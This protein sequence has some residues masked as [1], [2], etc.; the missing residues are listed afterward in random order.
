MNIPEFS[1]KRKVSVSMI[2]MI[3]VIFGL[4]SITRLGLD[5]LPDLEFPTVSVI[6][7]YKGASSEDIE[8]TITENI[9][10]LVSSVKDVKKITSTSS[11]GVSAVRVEF[12]WGTNIDFA[13]QDIRDQLGLYQQ[14]MPENADNPLVVKFDVSQLPIM[15]YGV[16]AN[17]TMSAFR[18]KKLI[19]DEV[20]PRLERIEG[21]A[22]ALVYSSDERE[23][24]VEVDKDALIARNLSLNQVMMALVSENVNTPGGDVTEG[25]E[26]LT[27]RAVGEFKGLDDIN[28][29]IVGLSQR[30]EPIYIKD[31]AE[32]KDTF[33]ETH[34]VGRIQGEK[35]VFLLINK[36]SGANVA[37]VGRAVKQEVE[38]L[39]GTLPQGI[40]FTS[41]MDQEDMVSRVTS[42]TANTAWQGGL[43]AVFMIFLF[44]RNWRPTLIIS[45]SLPLSIIATF[46]GMYFAGYTFNIMTLA[47]LALGVGML[48]DN[49][50]VVI[51]NTFRHIEQ[52]EPVDQAAISG[53]SEVGMAITASTLTNVVVFLPIVFATGIV[54]KITTQMAVTVT[55]SMLSSLL[56][57]LTTVPLFSSVFYR[58]KSG[59]TS[60]KAMKEPRFEAGRRTYRRLLTT[61][62]KKKHV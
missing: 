35:G 16:T 55:I 41:V 6:T 48:V 31:I 12:E 11:E 2:I 36:R 53:A 18:L 56:V 39:A 1:V 25:N 5:L 45:I 62:L 47:G 22:S 13:A 50:I 58:T 4:I 20:K 59:E 29:V 52:G 61:A 57:A 32:V 21:V 3:V 17:G 26:D 51:E 28:K 10:Q 7:T 60:K 8:S 24:R 19:E 27:V 23:I 15:F 9:E 43:L 46:I 14:Y 54:A 49:S 44:L 33:K 42:N 40:K 38:R 37:T 34:T 30:G